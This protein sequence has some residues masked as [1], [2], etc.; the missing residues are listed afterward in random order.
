[1][2][3]LIRPKK[4]VRRFA[5][6]SFGAAVLIA[7]VPAV[8]NAACPSSATTTALESFGDNS[9]YTLLTGGSFESGAPG[10]TLTNAEV[11]SGEGAMSS[12]HL[13]EIQSNGSAVSPQFCVSSEYPS[14]RFFERSLGGTTSRSSLNVTLRWSVLGLLPVSTTVA[15]LKPEASW[16]LTPVLKLAKALP[17]L[18]S[19]TL[20]VSVAFQANQGGTWAIDDVYIDPYSR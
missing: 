16:T 11:V 4:M 5:A 12:S 17:L 3:Y 13:L 2:P 6:T 7:A 14:F 19:Q 8:A 9:A 1:M 20:T 10:W 15:T 18:P